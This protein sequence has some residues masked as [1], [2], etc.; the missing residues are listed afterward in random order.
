MHR[1]THTNSIKKSTHK[2]KTISFD[3]A[4]VHLNFKININKFLIVFCKIY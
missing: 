3:D 1:L 4:K 2:A